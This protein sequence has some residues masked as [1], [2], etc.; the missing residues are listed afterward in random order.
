MRLR[1][2]S[3]TLEPEIDCG[4]GDTQRTNVSNVGTRLI[5]NGWQMRVCVI[6]K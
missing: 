6:R 3:E 5:L 4:A 2:D 1:G